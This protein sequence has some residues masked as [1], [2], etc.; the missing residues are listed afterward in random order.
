MTIIGIDPGNTHSAAEAT[1]TLT[2][3]LPPLPLRP[4]GRAHWRVKAKATKLYRELAYLRAKQAIGKAVPP[5]WPKATVQCDFYFKTAVM[6]DPDN[7][8]AAMKAGMD[9]IADAGFVGND[10]N[11]WPLRPTMRKDAKNPRVEITIAEE[12]E[13]RLYQP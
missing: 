10:R 1:Y 4:N 12:T 6:W 11:L 5:R 9:G 2:M 13:R 8:V 7:A 3:P